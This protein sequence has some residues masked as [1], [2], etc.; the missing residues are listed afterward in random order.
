VGRR[1]HSLG[2]ILRRRGNVEV[3]QRGL[4]AVA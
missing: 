2:S 4:V 1:L 3:R